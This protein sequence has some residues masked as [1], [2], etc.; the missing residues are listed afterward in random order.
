MNLD[1]ALDVVNNPSLVAYCDYTHH[2]VYRTIGEFEFG[3][4]ESY[5]E[6]AFAF[7]YVSVEMAFDDELLE[8]AASDNDDPAEGESAC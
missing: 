2:H 8:F 7:V 3:Y 5:D 1:E 6:I 4:D